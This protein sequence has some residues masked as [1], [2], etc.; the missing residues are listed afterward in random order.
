[1]R[2]VVQNTF[3]SR[4]SWS[5]IAFIFISLFSTALSLLFVSIAIK[6][7]EYQLVTNDRIRPET[8]LILISIGAKVVELSF[9]TSLIAF[10][11]QVLSR[12]AFRMNGV[13]LAELSMWRWIVQPSTLITQYGTAKYA[14]NTT[15]GILALLGAISAVLYA[16]AVSALGKSLLKKT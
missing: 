10:L 5:N 3:N 8:V 1:M 14:G 4:L 2:S 16:P 13:S 11:S 15:L 12:R 6:K 9:T 7:T